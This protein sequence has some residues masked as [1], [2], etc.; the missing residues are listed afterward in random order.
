M[1]PKVS[2]TQ[3]HYAKVPG[4]EK[5]F[6][7]QDNESGS[8]LFLVEPSIKPLLLRLY[9]SLALNVITILALAGIGAS[10]FFGH[11]ILNKDLRRCSSYSK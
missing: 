10:Q 8:T 6:L 4:E 3:G 1:I 9:L 11:S 7:N 2:K 5:A